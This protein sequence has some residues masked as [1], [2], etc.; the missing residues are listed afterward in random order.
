M[1]DRGR[2]AQG[3]WLEPLSGLPES[4]TGLNRDWFIGAV[5]RLEAA[6]DAFLV[7]RRAVLAQ[8]PF[9]VHP[10]DRDL[11]TDDALELALDELLRCVV[12]CPRLGV[13]RL[14][15]VG[16]AGH[17]ITQTLCIFKEGDWSIDMDGD[18]IPGRHNFAMLFFVAYQF[19]VI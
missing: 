17:L 7:C 2:S 1:S 15:P 18:I 9:A 14:V 11:E 5:S 6:D 19:G 13:C 8:L 12:Q 16:Q 3:V 4:L 10:A